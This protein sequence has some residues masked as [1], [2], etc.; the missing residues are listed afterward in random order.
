MNVS[1]VPQLFKIVK[2]SPLL[3]Y[4]SYVYEYV[5]KKGELKLAGIVLAHRK[6]KE[7]MV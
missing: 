4:P 6:E 7:G 5:Q 3:A 2:V 1:K